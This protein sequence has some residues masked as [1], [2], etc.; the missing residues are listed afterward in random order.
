[1]CPTIRTP[2]LSLLFFWVS[3][4]LAVPLAARVWIS[5]AFRRSGRAADERSQAEERALGKQMTLDSFVLAVKRGRAV[6]PK[7]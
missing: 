1:M 4:W 3:A 2:Q 6:Y 7:S 5:P